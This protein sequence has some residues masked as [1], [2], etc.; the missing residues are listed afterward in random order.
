M[1]AIDGAIAGAI[2]TWL[3]GKA[4]TALYERED[5]TA[6]QRED[7]A[8]SGKT[9]YGVAAEKA[10]SLAGTDLSDNQRKQYGQA[11]H[12]ALGIGAGALYGALRP[13]SEVASA[14]GGLL[15]GAT[16][17]LLMDETVTP[18]LGLTPGPAAFPWQTHARGLA[19]HLVFGTIANT[20]LSAIQ[21][22]A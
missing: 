10:A 11:I 1:D 14:A 19:G 3:M 8:R 13:R 12:W 9:A 20:T 2:A 6:R 22:A 18:A 5:K 16:F 4:T 15:F 7:Q 17:W 21:P